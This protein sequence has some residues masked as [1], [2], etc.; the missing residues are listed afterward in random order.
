[1]SFGVRRAITASFD[2]F[3]HIA[4]SNAFAARVFCLSGAANLG[5][6]LAQQIRVAPASLRA[7]QQR[8]RNIQ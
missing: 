5:L 7:F 6:H 3:G 1:M 4:S 8:L 2:F